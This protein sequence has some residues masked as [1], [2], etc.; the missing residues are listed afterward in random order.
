MPFGFSP[1]SHEHVSMPT[2]GCPT[3]AL[4]A[5]MESTS[6]PPPFAKPKEVYVFN[7][8]EENQS[9][10]GMQAKCLKCEDRFSQDVALESSQGSFSPELFSAVNLL[11]AVS[12]NRGLCC[13]FPL[14]FTDSVLEAV[15]K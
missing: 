15:L 8:V 5:L 4:L 2:Q 10:E 3:T 7:L 13:L 12:Q 9:I 6:S 14:A 11:S 1:A